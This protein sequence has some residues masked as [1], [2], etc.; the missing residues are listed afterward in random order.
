MNATHQIS[1]WIE[2]SDHDRL[3][4]DPL[5]SVHMI[6]YNHGAF[7]AEAIEGVLRQQ[8]EYPYELV[9]G[10]DCSKDNTRQIALEYQRR[11]P[12]KIR[13]IYSDSNV[14]MLRNSYRVFE[15]CRGK[16]VALC[17]GD[18]YWQNPQKLQK[19]T[20]AFECDDN[21]VLVHS[22]FDVLS[23]AR[24]ANA[25][26]RTHGL[27]IATG[28]VVEGLLLHNYVSTC[29]VCLRTE[30]IREYLCSPFAVKG[31]AMGDYPL[32]L[33]AARKG[34][35]EYLDESLATYRRAAG[36]VMHSDVKSLVK[37][38]LAQRRVREDYVEMFGCSEE[39]RRK[40]QITNNLNALMA[41]ALAGDQKMFFEEFKWFR[42][43]NPDWHGNFKYRLRFWLMKCNL[44]WLLRLRYYFYLRKKLIGLG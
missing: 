10:E 33:F 3:V 6:S 11:F 41:S 26:N 20:K 35:V 19:Q 42:Q 21:C 17:E 37:I 34:R 39:T 44:S 24:L 25:T 16:Y 31:Y 23:G 27:N 32:W 5:V 12:E 30:I 28:D 9:I 15:C 38:L 22:D 8:T 43:N 36:S 18:D 1:D 13:V 29:T 4:K 14:G 40:A 7:L 2:I